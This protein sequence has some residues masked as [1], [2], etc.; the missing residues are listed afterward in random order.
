M[1]LTRLT[2]ILALAAAPVWYFFRTA[3]DKRVQRFSWNE[4]FQTEHERDQAEIARLNQANSLE[5]L[6]IEEID[7]ARYCLSEVK[8]TE[9]LFLPVLAEE[10]IW[11]AEIDGLLNSA[12]GASVAGNNDYVLVFRT[13]IAARVP[14]DE[15]NNRALEIGEV[16]EKCDS[17][18]RKHSEDAR[19]DYRL[20]TLRQIQ[21]FAQKTLP[22][23]RNGRRKIHGLI[24][25]ANGE[26]ATSL[27][28]AVTVSEIREQIALSKAYEERQLFNMSLGLGR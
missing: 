25:L 13:F 14:D 22:E 16:K 27:E 4:I 2:A 23:L 21:E 11:K 5:R 19:L 24:R 6:R 1:Q 8:V 17:A 26:T 15:L 12:S 7:A 18:L 20:Y 3:T 10:R 9:S 28:E